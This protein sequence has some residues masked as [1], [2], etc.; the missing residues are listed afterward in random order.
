MD[1]SLSRRLINWTSWWPTTS[2]PRLRS[3]IGSA[4]ATWLERDEL[5]DDGYTD[6][7]AARQKVVEPQG[8]P[9][10]LKII[11]ELTKRILGRPPHLGEP[12]RVLRLDGRGME[13]PSRISADGLLQRAPQIP[14]YERAG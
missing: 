5:C 12:R 14:Q 4:G 3:P 2:T 13:S 7:I 11:I 9:D 6:Y 8:E 1:A 10:D